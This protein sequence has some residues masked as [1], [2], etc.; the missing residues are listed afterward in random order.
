VGGP[1]EPLVAENKRRGR[2]VLDGL[3]RTTSGTGDPGTEPDAGAPDPAGNGSAPAGVDAPQ[4]PSG[5]GGGAISH[6]ENGIEREAYEPNWY[7]VLA[8]ESYERDPE[9]SNVEPSASEPAA[10]VNPEDAHVEPP[11]ADPEAETAEPAAPEAFEPRVSHGFETGEPTL[12]LARDDSL[13]VEPLGNSYADPIPVVVEPPV[14]AQVPVGLA[15]PIPVVV[16]PPFSEPSPVSFDPGD[17]LPPT[18][19]AFEPEEPPAHPESESSEP[20]TPDW[21]VPDPETPEVENPPAQPTWSVEDP[22]GYE[23]GSASDAGPEPYADDPGDPAPQPPDPPEGIQEP[24][25]A[26]EPSPVPLSAAD[27]RSALMDLASR[28]LSD[29]DLEMVGLLVS[30]PEHDIRVHAVRTLQSRP[31]AVPAEVVRTALRDPTDEVRAEAVALEAARSAPDPAE[32]APFVAARRWPVSQQAAFDVLPSLVERHHDPEAVVDAILLAVASM[33]SAPVDD[34]RAGF[35]ALIRAIGRPRL[36]DALELPDDRRLGAARLLLE[37]GSEEALRAV[38]RHAT[39][40]IE[41][42]R[43]AA[44]AAHDQLAEEP[45]PPSGPAS[46]YEESV[47]NE[48]PP[49]EPEWEQVIEA[50]PEAPS[51][52]EPAP[53]PEL[54]M[55]P[56]APPA[57]WAD[58]P[59][60]APLPPHPAETDIISVMARALEDPDEGVRQRAAK[61]LGEM[62]RGVL[63]AWTR[64]ALSSREHDDVTAG[65]RVAEAAGLSEVAA[66]ILACAATLQPEE[67]GPLVGALS[68]FNFDPA[69][70]VAVAANVDANNRP[71]AIRLLWQVSGRKVLPALRRLLEDSSGPVR[72]AV[73]DVFGESGDPSAIEVAHSVLEIDSSP[74]VRAT[75]IRVIG[76]AGL[77]Q[78]TSSLS[79][80]LDDPDPDVRATAVELLPHGMAGQ[81]GELLL[82]ALSDEDDRVWQPAMRHLASLPERD[83]PIL[84]RAITEIQPDRRDA[85]ISLLERTSRE[86]LGLV[87]LDHFSDADEANRMLAISL[88][89]RSGTTEAMRGIIGT[90]VD[91]LPAV[92]RAGA[93][94]LADLRDHEAIPA[95]TQALTDPDAE[96]REEAILALSALDDERVLEPLID[97]LKDP[98]ER[99]RQVAGDALIRWN[100]PAVARRLVESLTSPA[101]RRP[102]SELLARMGTSAVDPL[103]DLLREGHPELAAT[104]GVTLERL[105][106]RDVFLQRLGSMDPADRLGAVEALGALGGPEAVEGLTRALSDPNENIRITALRALGDMG[107]R[108]AIDAVQRSAQGDPLPE[109]A[110]AAEEAL[111]KLQS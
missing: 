39:D 42:V 71:D 58:A 79:Q 8:N 95:L 61:E 91:P 92:R 29:D 106:G 72:V 78:R 49:S 17:A 75:A 32:L 3:L 45:E 70:L 104:V 65:T 98:E 50:E 100:S 77:D 83:L 66:E 97:G 84:W 96:V 35:L 52:A 85:L 93:A 12:G 27:R 34:E 22:S 86:R 109:V 18:I 4:T 94:A 105:V 47:W 51:V 25:H 73:L 63:L 10:P 88:A 6:P 38:A 24:E 28:G 80:A 26:V 2:G 64:A 40:S 9:P 99:V 31:D 1:K 33:D 102:A 110:A 69:D 48:A 41:E 74:V 30:D 60:A 37:D 89:A 36:I 81:A 19:E 107:D 55:E 67:R 53:V 11:R 57:E 68:F 16:E 62:D 5:P 108:S 56:A 82:K 44:E 101:L 46:P 43:V 15:D 54:A 23:E 14:P 76:R 21:E 90:L 20:S 13:R 87:A 103:V 7:R 59:D 111:R